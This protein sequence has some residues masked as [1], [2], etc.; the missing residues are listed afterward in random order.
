SH[1][2][3][4]VGGRKCDSPRLSGAVMRGV[5]YNLTCGEEGG[6]E[7]EL[8]EHCDDFSDQFTCSLPYLLGL[9][10]PV[11]VSSGPLALVAEV[12]PVVGGGQVAT[13]SSAPPA[14]QLLTGY[15][16]VD[17]HFVYACNYSDPLDWVRLSKCPVQSAYNLSVC[18]TSDSL[19]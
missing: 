8:Q 2:L 15:T 13:V 5:C 14:I 9:N 12:G 3:V 10:L 11:L 19:Y 6:A 7:Q 16:L 18:L 17:G 1:L 4:T